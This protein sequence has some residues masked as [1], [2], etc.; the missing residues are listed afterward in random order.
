MLAHWSPQRRRA[1]GPLRVPRICSLRAPLALA[2]G[3]L[4][5]VNQTPGRAPP[6]AEPPWPG[7]A[8]LSWPCR[9]HEARSP[10]VGLLGQAEPC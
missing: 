5:T 8:G 7:L 9:V 1:L 2:Q 4:S 6:S 3:H 10:S